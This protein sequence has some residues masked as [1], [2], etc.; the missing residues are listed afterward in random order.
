MEYNESVKLLKSNK[1]TQKLTSRQR[2]PK[3]KFIMTV[4]KSNSPMHPLHYFQ[5]I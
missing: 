4:M 2:L 5:W 3:I 1:K